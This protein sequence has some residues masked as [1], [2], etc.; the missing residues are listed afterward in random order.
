VFEILATHRASGVPIVKVTKP[1]ARDFD[2]DGTDDDTDGYPNDP[3][4]Q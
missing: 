2:G 4:M 1:P 3:A